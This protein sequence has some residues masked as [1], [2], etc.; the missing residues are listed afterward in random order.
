MDSHFKTWHQQQDELCKKI[1]Q[2]LRNRR[3]RRIQIMTREAHKASRK[4]AKN[5]E[6][7]NTMQFLTWHLQSDTRTAYTRQ[8]SAHESA[9]YAMSGG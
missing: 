1:D 5:R 9:P 4:W 3:A 6:T 8:T 2:A 7:L